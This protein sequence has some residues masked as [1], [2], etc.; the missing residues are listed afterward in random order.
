M[1]KILQ[2]I[3]NQEHGLDTLNIHV[4]LTV[5]LDCDRKTGVTRFCGSLLHINDCFLSFWFIPGAPV[6]G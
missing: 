6:T 3:F 5:D 4:Q 1:N 2:I